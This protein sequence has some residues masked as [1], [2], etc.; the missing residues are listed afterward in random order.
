MRIPNPFVKLPL[1]FDQTRLINEISQFGAEE[2]RTHPSGL[3][4]NSSL[5]LVSTNGEENDDFV[6]PMR[7]SPRL[8]RTPYIRQ[9]MANFDAVVGRSRLMRLAP[10]ASVTRHTDTHYFWRNHLRIHIPIVTDPNVVFYC[11]EEKVHMAAGESWTFDNWLMHS[12]ENRSEISRIHLV[13]DTVGSAGLWKM[14]E[15]VDNSERQVGFLAGSNPEVQFEG[16][17]GLLAMPPAELRADLE[18]LIEDIAEKNAKDT[19]Q[20]DQLKSCT[21]DFIRDW[22]SQWIAHGPTISG[23]AGFKSLQKSYA[24][25]TERVPDELLL[26]SNGLSFKKAVSSTLDAV[27]AVQQ[28]TEGED[29]GPTRGSKA[30]FG[31][32]FDRPVF[33]VAAPRSGSTLLFETLALNRD[34]WSIGDESHSHFESIPSLRPSEQ[35]PSNRLLAEM[36]T[37]E[38]VGTLTNSLVADLRNGDGQLFVEL[39]PQ[40]RP[41]EVRFLEKTPKNSLRIPFIV[42]A[43][44]GARFIFLFRDARQNISSLLDSWRSGRYVTY[45]HLSG[46]PADYPWSHLLIPGW[47][48]LI[49]SSLV[50]VVARQWIVTNQT[51]LADLNELPSER[52]C[53][54]DYDT[55]LAN[56]KSEL[57]RLC[58]FSKIFFGPRMVEVASR[59]LKP[60]KYTLTAPYPKKW[61]KNAADLEPVISS[62]QQTMAT[63]RNLV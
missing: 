51:I 49:K 19:H 1:S 54:I 2:W 33:I 20:I 57:Q 8:Q 58:H 32:R 29:V 61:M 36:A 31:V 26:G 3:E 17:R 18:Q 37:P 28:S 52:W 23:L 12:V 34:F 47:Q 5:I 46:W 30:G 22:N 38:V 39:P 40:A 63:L 6:G 16:F 25:E 24:S 13:I 56:T 7:P 21:T 43:F 45:E 35:N 62:T 27:L 14:I 15:G 44:P 42:K 9:I 10:G 41:S 4:G 50:E 53:A 11:G 59:P 60:S 48:D 55:L